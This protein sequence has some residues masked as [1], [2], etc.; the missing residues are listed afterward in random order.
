MTTKMRGSTCVCFFCVFDLGCLSQARTTGRTLAT[1]NATPPL[2]MFCCSYCCN[3][4]TLSSVDACDIGRGVSISRYV[5]DYLYV[6]WSYMCYKNL[7]RSPKQT[8]NWDAGS[9]CDSNVFQ[10]FNPRLVAFF[11]VTMLG[12]HLGWPR[13]HTSSRVFLGSI[14]FAASDGHSCHTP[15]NWWMFILQLLSTAYMVHDES[16]YMSDALFCCNT[17][18]RRLWHGPLGKESALR[19]CWMTGLKPPRQ[20]D[21]SP[22][23][24]DAWCVNSLSEQLG[25]KK[26]NPEMGKM[27]LSHTILVVRGWFFWDWL[28]S[29]CIFWDSNLYEHLFQKK[30][31][32]LYF[33][34]LPWMLWTREETLNLEDGSRLGS[35]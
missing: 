10:C 17:K 21:A 29:K 9:D 11:T 6:I 8:N 31:N 22:K 19:R 12:V 23:S 28:C 1:S 7:S 35:Y 5:R 26:Q 25:N 3:K 32:T 13:N 24:V 16:L 4:I 15:I 18:K 20:Q 2:M 34:K 33:V 14:F 27:L 30:N